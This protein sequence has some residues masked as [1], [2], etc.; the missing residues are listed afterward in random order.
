M[1]QLRLLDELLQDARFGVRNLTQ[2]RG[3]AV[4]AVL[5]LSLG[6]MAT[7]AIFSVVHGVILDPFPYKD[8]DSLMS[9]RVQ[10]PVG[11]LRP[12]LLQHRPLPGIR[13]AGDDFRWRH[14]FDHQRRAVA[15]GGEPQRLRGNYVT[16]NTFPVMGVPPLPGRARARPVPRQVARGAALVQG[17]FPEQPLQRYLSAGC[18]CLNFSR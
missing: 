7:T 6:I 9:I 1:T 8:V 11:A 17:N 14:R 4:I 18:R 15:G 12:H 16:T 10:E 2:N 3:F 5:S 13:R